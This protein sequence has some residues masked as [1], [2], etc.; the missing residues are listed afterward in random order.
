VECERGTPHSSGHETLLSG[1][2]SFVVPIGPWV[3]IFFVS[4][5]PTTG[6]AMAQAVSRQ[7]HGGGPG[8]ILGQSMWDLWWRKWHWDRFYPEYFG[9][10]LSVLFHWCFIMR[11]NGKK[12]NIFI[13]GLHN[14][15]QVCGASVASAAGP[16]TTNKTRQRCCLHMYIL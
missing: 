7:P 2:I 5:T 13:T 4:N 9:F 3:L 1:N 16:Y 14:N 11:K 6:R 8:S 10:T 12:L 15:P